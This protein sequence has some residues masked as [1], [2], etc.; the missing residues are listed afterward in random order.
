[1]IIKA[2]PASATNGRVL[3]PYQ[4]IQQRTPVQI[5]QTLCTG[6]EL[7]VHACPQAVLKSVP[8]PSRLEGVVAIVYNPGLCTACR[9][10]EDVCPDFCITVR[11]TTAQKWR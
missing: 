11:D 4:N 5:N 10:C 1:M 7:C 2:A 8:D 6:C 3:E 9:Q